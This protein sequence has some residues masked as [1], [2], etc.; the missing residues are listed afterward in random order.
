[1]NNTSQF[2]TP[3]DPLVELQKAFCMFCF[4]SQL[5]IGVR[6]EIAEILAGQRDSDI[7]MYKLAEGKILM[8]ANLEALPISCVSKKVA[9]EFPVNPRTLRYDEVAFTPTATPKMT[10]NYWVP[11]SVEPVAGDWSVIETF[12]LNIICDRDRT[13]FDYL[14]KF[15]AHMWQKPEEKPG[16][17]IVLLGGQGS[18]KGTLFNLLQSIWS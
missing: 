13:L 11:P 1:M 9:E 10:L 3:L 14:I 2:A 17:M 6:K 5:R 4:D 16:I 12:L 7:N 18:G 8:R 15:L